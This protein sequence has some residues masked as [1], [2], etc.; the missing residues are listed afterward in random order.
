MDARKEFLRIMDTQTEIAF[1]TCTASQPNVRIVNFYFDAPANT[2]YFATFA[3]NDKVKE[4]E[5]NSLVAF[6]TVPHAGTEHV[7]AK[8]FAKKSEHTIYAHACNFIKKIPDYKE[9]IDA[10]GECLIVY[11]VQFKSAVVVL[12]FE[13]IETYELDQAKDYI[14]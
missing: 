2:L 1:A 11:E 7:R 10:A 13:N 8:G 12:D 6:T 9:I 3:D 14:G 5:V 4:I